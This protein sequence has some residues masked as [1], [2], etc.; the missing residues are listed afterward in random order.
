MAGNAHYRLIIT[1]EKEKGF[2]NGGLKNETAIYRALN[3]H[4]GRSAL[5]QNAAEVCVS[6]LISER[7]YV[8]PLLFDEDEAESFATKLRTSGCEVKIVPFD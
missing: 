8:F 6:F 3:N 7:P 4:L 2:W 5:G 1:A